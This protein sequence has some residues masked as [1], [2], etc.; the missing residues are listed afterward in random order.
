M[1][2]VLNGRGIDR[3]EGCRWTGFR[4]RPAASASKAC[5]GS[6]RASFSRWVLTCLGTDREFFIDNLLVRI[7]LIIVM[8]RWTGLAPWEF[9]FPFP[10]NL[11]STF[12]VPQEPLLSLVNNCSWTQRRLLVSPPITRRSFCQY[13]RGVEGPSTPLS[14][15]KNLF[16]ARNGGDE[17]GLQKILHLLD[18]KPKFNPCMQRLS[19][20]SPLTTGL[21]FCQYERGVDGD[22]LPV[23]K[24]GGWRPCPRTKRGVMNWVCKK[25][26]DLLGLNDSHNPC[27]QRCTPTNLR[28]TT[29]QKC[30]AVPRR[31]R[32]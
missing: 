32:I 29:S 13:E 6:A 16:P 2:V 7:H 20:A 12:L 25:T 30:E 26:L 1:D 15:W 27:M 4:T 11:T 22:L 17:P 14:Y 28:T 18:V 21:S 19:L 10:G 8:I 9:E 23:R 5:E 3:R 31:A 24:G